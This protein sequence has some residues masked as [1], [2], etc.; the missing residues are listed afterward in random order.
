[1]AAPQTSQVVEHAAERAADS[2]VFPPFDASNFVPEL[3]WLVIIF[4][5][6]YWMMSRV[7][8]PRVGSILEARRARISGDL[9]DATRMQRQASEAGAAY[10]AKLADAKAR[11][12]GLAQETHAR[13]LAE[14]EARRHAL[15]QDLN[16][17]LA[18]AEAQIQDTKARA[19]TNVA[20]I[21]R[22]AASAIIE[23]LTG[24]AADPRAVEAALSDAKPD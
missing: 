20:G 14:T 18:A 2:V 17:K 19:M 9:A 5:A 11:A 10:D 4:G 12:Q 15:D 8:L 6:L 7:A 3:I 23:H 1:M 24:K 16:G 22:D 13:L 21:A